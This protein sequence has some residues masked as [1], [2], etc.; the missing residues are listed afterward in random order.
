MKN[1]IINLGPGGDILR[2]TILL[3]ELEGEI[4]WLTRDIYKDILT[5]S[6]IKKVLSINNYSDITFS[7]KQ[8]WDRIISLNEEL[9]ALN[10]VKNLK[11]QKIIGVYLN[12]KNKIDYT[13]DSSYWFDMS[14]SSK[15]GIDTA[16]RLKW[17]NKKSYPQI[18]IES[19]GKEWGGQEYDLGIPTIK[20]KGIIGIVNVETGKWPNKLWSRFDE[21]IV[22]LRKEGYS[23]K[24]LEMR[25]TIKEHIIDVNS[26]ELIVTGDNL[27]MHIAI[28]LKK[29]VVALFS[30][31]GHPR[32]GASRGKSRKGKTRE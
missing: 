17:D 3:S 4:Y 26:C 21:L 31:F 19:I 25:P 2:T 22:R 8:N 16:N 13:K 29:K 32:I 7:K 28:A 14:L 24:R 23:I 9:E 11:Y 6:K 5:S 12:E 27:T 30:F 1:L 20:S 15:L 18:M 10:I